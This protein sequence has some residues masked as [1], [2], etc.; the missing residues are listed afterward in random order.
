MPQDEIRTVHTFS[1]AF[2]EHVDLILGRPRRGGGGATPLRFFSV[3]FLEDKTSAP[4]V[5]SN[6]SFIPRA[7]FESSSVMVSFYGYEI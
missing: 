6:C 7:L 3:C 5:L 2:F 1:S 4:D